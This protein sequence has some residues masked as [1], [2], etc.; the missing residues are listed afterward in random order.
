MKKSSRL[1]K[2][3]IKKEVRACAY[4]PCEN[5]FTWNHKTSNL[6]YCSMKCAYNDMEKGGDKK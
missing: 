2:V 6:R 4:A 1:P 5:T 3:K